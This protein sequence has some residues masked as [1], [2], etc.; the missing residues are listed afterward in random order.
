ME[1]YLEVTLRRRECAKHETI[2]ETNNFT[3]L[4]SEM[5]GGRHTRPTAAGI[6]PIPV[7]QQQRKSRQQQ[8]P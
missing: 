8:L 5:Y 3:T 7:S 4:R 1:W 2:D 6:G